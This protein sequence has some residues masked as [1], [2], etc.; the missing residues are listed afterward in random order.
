MGSSWCL[1]VGDPSFGLWVG[2]DFCEPVGDM[3]FCRWVGDDNLGLCVGDVFFDSDADLDAAFN[4][5]MDAYN[6]NKI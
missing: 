3:T 1:C 2:D 4:F 6:I 5:S